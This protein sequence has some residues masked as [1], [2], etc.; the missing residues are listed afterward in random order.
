M[1]DCYAALTTDRPYRK[2]WKPD[3]ALEEIERCAGTHFD[4][5]L[6]AVFLQVMRRELALGEEITDYGARI[7][8]DFAV[9]H[10]AQTEVEA[11]ETEAVAT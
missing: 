1:G 2:G 9:E 3:A 5:H 8:E 11:V 10:E 7:L 4:P 6:C